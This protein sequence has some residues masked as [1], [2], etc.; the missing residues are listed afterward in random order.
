MSCE[1]SCEPVIAADSVSK[2]FRIYEK[3]HHRLLQGFWR[4]RKRYY[5]DF[6]ALKRVSLTITTGETVGVVGRNG[7][8]KSTLL[9]II[10]GTLLPTEGGVETKGRI[11]ALLELGA[12]FNPEFSGRDNVY[13][14]ASIMGLG[15]AEIDACFEGI[16]RFAEIGEFIDQPVKTYSSGMFVRLA[17]SVAIHL[18]PQILII[19]EALSVGDARF[20]AKCLNRIK[21]MKE[22]GKTIL[23]VSHDIS[24][25]RALCDRVLWLDQGEVRMIGDVFSV[26]AQYTQFLFEDV[27]E[28]EIPQ[29]EGEAIAA[30]KAL[31][32]QPIN[33]WGSCPGLIQSAEVCGKDGVRSD[34]FSNRE[35]I[36]IVIIVNIPEDIDG[37]Y[38]GLAFSIKNTRG[39]DLIVSSTW[40]EGVT[41]EG[42]EGR[43]V[44]VEFAFENCLNNGKYIL[45]AAVED[46]TNPVIEYLEYI[47]GAQYFSSVFEQKLFGEF[48]PP[49][50]QLVTF[51]D[52]ES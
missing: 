12:G 1:K 45:V 51:V 6:H 4:G 23:F 43:R 9:Q 31:S 8:G 50:E 19:D 44:K 38:L 20:Q 18:D 52:L 5:R 35:R 39:N 21:E 27:V 15:R 33:R 49:I 48:L 47:E 46:R 7:S 13:L 25:V 28:S 42:R 36:H 41:F 34:M 30:D 10:C 17:F 29:N 14:N 26:T 24:S 16:E 40:D 22:S 11:A 32:M 2:V 3:P 37:R